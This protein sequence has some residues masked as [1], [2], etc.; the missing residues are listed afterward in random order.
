ML[1]TG[2]CLR[3]PWHSKWHSGQS[4]RPL[5]LPTGQSIGQ[6]SSSPVPQRQSHFQASCLPFQSSIL[7]IGTGPSHTSYVYGRV[8]TVPLARHVVINLYT[9]NSFI[10]NMTDAEMEVR[11][12]QHEWHR[13]WCQTGVQPMGVWLRLYDYVYSILDVSMHV[14]VASNLPR[15]RARH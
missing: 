10:N 1:E 2:F 7:A 3:F 11:R 5:S 13:C 8:L 12:E 15:D 9:Y 4:G 6:C 14:C